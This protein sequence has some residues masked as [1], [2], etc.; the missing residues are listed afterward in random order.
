MQT[1]EKAQDLLEEILR[2]Y[3]DRGKDARFCQFQS[4]LN[5][6]LG[7]GERSPETSEAAFASSDETEMAFAES[8]FA[9]AA[10][11]SSDCLR[12]IA[13]KT[14]T[15]EMDEDAWDLEE[16]LEVLGLTE[17]ETDKQ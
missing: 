13:D 5:E 4:R 6:I 12:G 14:E 15:E 7:T 3:P 16:V 17:R 11:V 10:G 2:E 9:E 1:A 8:D